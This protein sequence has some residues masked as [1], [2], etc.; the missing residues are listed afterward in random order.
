[1]STRTHHRRLGVGVAL[2]LLLLLAPG[3]RGAPGPVR[4]TVQDSLGFT[5]DGSGA[6]GTLIVLAE[7][8][9]AERPG[10]LRVTVRRPG[11][12]PTLIAEAPVRLPPSSRTRHEILIRSYVGDL[13]VT[14]V[15][16]G[17]ELGRAQLRFDPLKARPYHGNP[18]LAVLSPGAVDFAYLQTHLGGAMPLVRVEPSQAPT[19]WVGWAHARLV[20]VHDLPTL[21]LTVPQQEALRQYAAVGGVLVLVSAL[22]PHEYQGSP[23]ASTLPVEPSG[24]FA[25][26]GRTFV[27]GRRARGKIV[28]G[29]DGVPLVGT[30]EYG[31]GRILQILAPAT[32]PSILG[33]R[34]S[35]RVWQ[36][37]SR[38]VDTR[39]RMSP[40][41]V[42]LTRAPELKPLPF[43]ALCWAVVTYF[44]VLGPANY[45]V[46]RRLDRTPWIFVTVPV[47]AGSF[48]ALSIAWQFHHRGAAPVLLETGRI[49][50]SRPETP[51]V[52]DGAAAL[53]SSYRSGGPLRYAPDTLFW[54][55]ETDPLRYGYNY[56]YG[57]RPEPVP[58]E[59]L[60]TLPDGSHRA[61][62]GLSAWSLARTRIVRPLPQA[63]RLAG[64]VALRPGAFA[65]NLENGLGFALTGCR[66]VGP[67]WWSEPFEL[68]RGR[69]A[70]RSP[71]R[72]LPRGTNLA[73]LLLEDF[74]QDD[75]MRAEREMHLRALGRPPATLV[76]GWLADGSGTVSYEDEP[77]VRRSA[78]LVAV[79]VEVAP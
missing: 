49:L 11:G 4:L 30:Q 69:T 27:Q 8:G 65:G 21:G 28:L 74:P 66:I 52:L 60:E 70:V 25:R 12:P 71:R 62:T 10:R 18:A 44:M 39:P 43:S 38:F 31:R 59:V 5:S 53:I 55:E 7:N 6:F 13:E 15:S 29:W 56:N 36:K 72:A 32:Q 42:L 40:D 73:D 2:V 33:G 20:V 46:L 76:V 78:V 23:L 54:L 57:Y 24:T 77:P 47:L 35:W 14:F 37:V 9:G 3:V 26:Q 34:Y 19:S 48:A 68:P 1:M 16:D 63:A 64:E 50:S 67:D 41:D 51:L 79:P 58:G 61:P 17:A 45:L 22:D 75:P